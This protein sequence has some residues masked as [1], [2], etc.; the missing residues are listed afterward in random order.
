NPRSALTAVIDRDEGH[1]S[2]TLT[3]RITAALARFGPMRQ[4]CGPRMQVR[5]Y[6]EYPTVSVV[7]GDD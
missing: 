7:R 3:A 2:G 4:A 1:P 5:V 6:D